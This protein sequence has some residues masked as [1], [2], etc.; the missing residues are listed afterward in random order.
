MKLINLQV[1]I[2]S[3]APEEYRDNS[4]E[5]RVIIP[6]TF[7]QQKNVPVGND[8]TGTGDFKTKS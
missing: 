5:I 8:E 6:K 2:S 7:V 3:G 1:S 4:V